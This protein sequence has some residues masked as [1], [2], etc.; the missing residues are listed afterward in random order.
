MSTT[1]MS[2]LV[3]RAVLKEELSR[4]ELRLDAFRLDVREDMNQ[5][6]KMILEQMEALLGLR[7]EP[8]KDLPGRVA[9]I[10][11]AN[12][13][14]RVSRLEAKVFPPKRASRRR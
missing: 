7:D 9:T 3:T 12:L 2:E 1:D 6:A 13:P 4:F 10:E 11:H 5:V 8:V 14:S